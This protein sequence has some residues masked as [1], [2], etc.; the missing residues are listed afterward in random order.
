MSDKIDLPI[1]DDGVRRSFISIT[2]AF[3]VTTT[4]KKMIHD[5]KRMIQIKK[6]NLNHFKD[7][8]IIRERDLIIK[9]CLM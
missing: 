4:A 5:P 6:H 7:G 8:N 3:L 2:A 1:D 9:Y